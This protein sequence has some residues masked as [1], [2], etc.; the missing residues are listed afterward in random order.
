MKAIRG[1]I[2]L[3]CQQL[4]SAPETQERNF[5]NLRFAAF[6]KILAM[7]IAKELKKLLKKK[8]KDIPKELEDTKSFGGDVVRTEMGDIPNRWKS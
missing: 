3:A 8:K 6:M 4:T 5:N 1:F 2:F 7:R